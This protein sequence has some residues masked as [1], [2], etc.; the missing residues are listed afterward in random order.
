[1][2]EIDAPA[3]FVAFPASGIFKTKF[4]EKKSW[5]NLLQNQPNLEKT[6]WESTGGVYVDRRGDGIAT[7]ASL[8]ALRQLQASSRIR[9]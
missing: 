2:R 6:L 4:E 7:E 9:E 8:F 5:E 3:V 1:M